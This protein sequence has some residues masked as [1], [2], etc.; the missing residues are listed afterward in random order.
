[1]KEALFYERIE[2][3]TVKCLLCPNNCVI[4]E[5]GTGFCNV[6]KNSG[7][8]LIAQTYSLVSSIALDPIEKKP[9]DYFMP[10]TR[11]LSVGTF[12]CNFKCG[13]CQNWTISQQRP[14]L[15]YITP[16]DLVET[17]GNVKGNIGIAYTYN[18]PSI[19]YEYVLE[20][21]RLAKEQ[22]LVNVLVTNGY[23]NPEPLK[24]L[25]PYVD[26]MNI[27]IK[28]FS[29]DYYKDICKGRLEPVKRTIAEA[30]KHCHIELTNLSVPGLN[31]SAGEMDDMCSWIA[32]VDKDIPLHIIPFRPLYKMKDLSPQT[33]KQLILL[34]QT[35]QKYLK[36]VVI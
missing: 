8:K 30:A 7:G 6:R 29:D 4:K 28:S 24:K 15:E 26:A 20:T 36:N 17:A 5:G 14:E 31:D 19:W 10:G 11:I 34:R 27:D 18:E 9:L 25:L 21:C 23:I 33:F 35:A 3:K 16:G 2:N 32:S 1:M 12:G 13:F 22:G